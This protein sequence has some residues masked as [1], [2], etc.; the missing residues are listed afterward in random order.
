M[1]NINRLTEKILKEAKERSKEILSLAE[2]DKI[3]IIA[4]RVKEAREIE[5]DIIRRAE[6][7]AAVK[8][9]RIVSNAQLQVRNNKLEAK[10]AVID[11]VFGRALEELS[12]MEAEQYTGFIRNS[13]ISLDVSGEQNLI[14]NERGKAFITQE[15]V[16]ALN[17]KMLKEGN[18]LKISLSNE[19]RSF[20][21]GFVLE[22]NGIEINNT[23][24]ALID[25]LR[26]E[27]E[28]EIT[29]VLFVI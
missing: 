8:K 10:Q 7:E 22:S 23:F 14:L 13:I 1:A 16:N 2:S 20:R 4:N 11:K 17:N 5:V 29:R 28:Y 21:G 12:N 24:E 3:K 9:H 6:S 18:D 25:F 27:L 26:D 19:T 15:F